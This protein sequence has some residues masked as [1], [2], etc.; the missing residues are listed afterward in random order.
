MSDSQQP[1]NPDAVFDD[2]VRRLDAGEAVDF[3]ALCR[4][5]LDIAPIL[6]QH[7]AARVMLE[8][9]LP[10]PL[11]S[12]EASNRE[13][14]SPETVALGTAAAGDDELDAGTPL[15]LLERLRDPSQRGKRYEVKD[16]I[17]RGGMGIVL[18][19]LDTDLR[20]KLAMKVALARGEK[21]GS[22]TAQTDTK[23]LSR[24]LEEAQITSQLDHPGIP[25]VH[26]IGIGSD[27]RVFF[28]M[29]LV[30]GETLRDIFAH[31]HE[32]VGGWSQV[33]ALRVIQKVCEA[34]S[35]AHAK[36]VIHR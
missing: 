34:M 1:P 11:D 26:E 6:R 7:E 16:E 12:V 13:P 31:V 3:D 17:G 30:R 5:H 22:D 25:P 35:Y 27:G 36:K 14:G 24:F 20:R 2:Y 21:R 33:R 28:T 10:G 29:R 18:K 8:Q 32:G 9:L 19:V 4:A 15:E 23:A